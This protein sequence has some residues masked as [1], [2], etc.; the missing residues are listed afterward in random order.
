MAFYN[1][2]VRKSID[3]FFLRIGRANMANSLDGGSKGN[4]DE[5]EG[6]EKPVTFP[7]RDQGNLGECTPGM[8]DEKERKETRKR[9]CS[10]SATDPSGKQ[11]TPKR[12]STRNRS[13]TQ[14]FVYRN[15]VSGTLKI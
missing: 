6:K 3:F 9:K 14:V 4:S 10:E 12:R 1:P 2:G 5:R 15:K 13:P 11:R 8:A 7:V